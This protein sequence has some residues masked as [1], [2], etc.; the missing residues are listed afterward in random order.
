MLFVRLK[1]GFYSLHT[2]LCKLHVL[3]FRQKEPGL[4]GLCVFKGL[5]GSGGIEGYSLSM[6]CW[7]CRLT[8]GKVLSYSFNSMF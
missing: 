8:T 5:P 4:F 2:L 3:I 6:Y 1:F 7:F